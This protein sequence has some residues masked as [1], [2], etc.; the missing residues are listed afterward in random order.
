MADIPLVH[1]ADATADAIRAIGLSTVGLLATAY[2]MEQDFYVG[3]LRERHALDVIVPNAE[4]RL[5]VHDIIYN[6]LCLG[7]ID[8]DSRDRYRQIMRGL[9]EQGAEGILLGCTEID[10][11]V[12][13]Q[14]ASVP[15]FDTT[16]L[17]VRKTVEL[18][19]R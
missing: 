18:A 16:L 12:G 1:I 11:L 10:L 13:P 3:R 6:E 9:V 19:L 7:I 2:T 5:S 4:D 8:D 15:V 17:H 14:D